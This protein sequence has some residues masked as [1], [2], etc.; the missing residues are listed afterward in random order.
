MRILV[1]ERA[2]GKEGIDFRQFFDDRHIGIKYELAFKTGNLIGVTTGPI[3]R[4]QRLQAPGCIFHADIEV[5]FAM[6]RSRMDE[7]GAGFQRNMITQ[8]NRHFAICIERMLE[9]EAFQLFSFHSIRQHFV[10][11]YFPGLHGRFYQILGHKQIFIANPD[12][13]V[14]EFFVGA[15][16]NV[17]GNSPGRCRPDKGKYLFRIG[18]FRHMAVEI[19]RLEFYINGE[20]FIVFIF[21]FRFSQCRF[22]MRAPV[23]GLQAFVDIA[24]LGHFSKYT[25]LGDFDR[26]LQCQVRMFPVTEDAKTDEIFTLHIDILKSVFTAFGT[27]VER[28]DFM[29]IESCILDDGM[30]DRQ[31]VCIPAGNIFRIM[32]S[33]GLVFQDEIFQAFI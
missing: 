30:F 20:G 21:D 2:L 23:Y 10:V 11:F 12:P 33:L 14:V 4:A 5:V 8:D 15:D 22:T 31:A 27:Q 19:Y 7:T 13:D 28:C 25:D 6:V 26:L 29:T 17:T 16:S 18:T 3:N 32:T 9:Y 24:F 1:T